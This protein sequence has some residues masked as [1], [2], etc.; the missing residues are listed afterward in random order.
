M[1]E[2]KGVE[3]KRRGREKGARESEG[4]V[5]REAQEVSLIRNRAK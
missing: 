1:E 5:E 4:R 2:I 3:R